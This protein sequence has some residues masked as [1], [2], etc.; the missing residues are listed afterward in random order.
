MKP[1]RHADADV[2]YR[3]MEP[4]VGD[5]W[6][7][8]WEPGLIGIVYEFDDEE[9]AQIAAGGRL[10]LSVHTEPIPPLS[11]SVIDEEV[12]RPV[13]EHGWKSIPELDDKERHQ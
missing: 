9:R 3:G 13:R 10:L 5:L 12:C 7:F 4:D 1:V 6:C 2:V 11:L 8:R